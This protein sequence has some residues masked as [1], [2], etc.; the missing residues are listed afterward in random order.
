MS[1]YEPELLLPIAQPLTW[2]KCWSLKVKLFKFKIRARN[3]RITLA[4]V[5]G[6]V[7]L[8]RACATAFMPS[9]CGMLV[10]RLATS[11]VTSIEPLGGLIFPIFRRKAPVSLM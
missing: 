4:G 9:R 6:E 10:Y 11:M 2:M 5:T 7:R 8:A 3:F 1:A